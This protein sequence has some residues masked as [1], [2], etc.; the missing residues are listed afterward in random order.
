MKMPANCWSPLINGPLL[1]RHRTQDLPATVEPS[2]YGVRCLLHSHHLSSTSIRWAHF[3]ISLPLRGPPFLSLYLPL[4]DPPQNFYLSRKSP[5]AVAT[6]PRRNVTFL[7]A[8]DWGWCFVPV[9]PPLL[10]PK[11][12]YTLEVWASMLPASFQ[13]LMWPCHGSHSFSHTRKANCPHTSPEAWLI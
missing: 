5:Q 2:S 4:W 7:R 3:L 11:D 9:S 12:S 6:T 10:L 13:G 1:Q 8:V